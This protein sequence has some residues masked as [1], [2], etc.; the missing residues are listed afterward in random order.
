LSYCCNCRA[1]LLGDSEE[2]TFIAH[3]KKPGQDGAPT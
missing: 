3:V 2:H 1:E